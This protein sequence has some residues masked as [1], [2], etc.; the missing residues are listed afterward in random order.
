MPIPKT[1][2]LSGFSIDSIYLSLKLFLDLGLIGVMHYPLSCL[3][4]YDSIVKP[5]N[6]GTAAAKLIVLNLYK[7]LLSFLKKK[8]VKT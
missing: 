6:C 3:R 4:S 5:F 7:K 8:Q 1:S 2:Q